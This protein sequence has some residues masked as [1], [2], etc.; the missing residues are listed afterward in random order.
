MLAYGTLTQA[1]ANL[2]KGEYWIANQILA[3]ELHN[4]DEETLQY[5]MRLMDKLEKVR[6][7]GQ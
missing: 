3:R 1:S 7:V 4:E 2:W 5:T 6:Y